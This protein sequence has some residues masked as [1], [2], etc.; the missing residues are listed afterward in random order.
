MPPAPQTPPE[1]LK[2][3]SLRLTQAVKA[4][5][6]EWRLPTWLVA[7][8]VAFVQ[9]V[10]ETFAELAKLH[11]E[12]K[13][14]LHQAAKRQGKNRPS[15]K[16]SQPAPAQVRS[17]RAKALMAQ[18][19]GPASQT[20]PLPNSPPTPVWAATPPPHA[21]GP[22][23]TNWAAPPT[24]AC[25]YRYDI[26]PKSHRRTAA[27]TSRPSPIRRATGGAPP[28]NRAARFPATVSAISA[29]NAVTTAPRANCA[30][31]PR[32]L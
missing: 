7:M 26:E 8:I 1:K 12:G 21:C 14:P 18:A 10:V 9:E 11:R 28:V 23:K 25:P 20:P 29:A 31:G 3:F 30:S 15:G 17:P 2:E 27:N 22:P 19:P 4:D 16:P 13:L 6:A 5:C 24:N 32:R